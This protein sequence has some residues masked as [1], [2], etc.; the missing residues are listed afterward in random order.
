M[1]HSK[2]EPLISFRLKPGACVTVAQYE[3]MK[4]DVIARHITGGS[5]IG[6]SFLAEL[7]L[8]GEY[9]YNEVRENKP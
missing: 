6:D 8:D 2:V 9:R 4:R 1:P 7:L 5:E 3:Q